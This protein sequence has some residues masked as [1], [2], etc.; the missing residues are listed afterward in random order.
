[1]RDIFFDPMTWA[2]SEYRSIRPKFFYRDAAA[3]RP[4][5][6]INKTKY[7][8]GQM[9]LYP[10]PG[11]NI[12]ML[13]IL[14]FFNP[15]MGLKLFFICLPPLIFLNGFQPLPVPVPVPVPAPALVAVPVLALVPVLVC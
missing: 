2:G 12:L 7:L 8:L 3:S 13:F 4:P 15:M 14:K 9:Y 5:H 6:R 10:D 1:M 11:Q